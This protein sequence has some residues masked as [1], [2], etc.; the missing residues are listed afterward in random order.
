MMTKLVAGSL[1]TGGRSSPWGRVHI[2]CSHRRLRGGASGDTRIKAPL[3]TSSSSSRF[4]YY[5]SKGNNEE[6]ANAI[7]DDR[8]PLYRSQKYL[9]SLPLPE[10]TDTVAP[11]LSSAI[12]LCPTWDQVAK[13]GKAAEDFPKQAEALQARL[14]AHADARKN[15]SWL[16]EWWNEGYLKDRN[17]NVINVSYFFRLVDND[18]EL[19]EGDRNTSDSTKEPAAIQQQ[20]NDGKGLER[21]AAILQGVATYAERILNGSRP[22]D[23]LASSKDKAPVA[24]CSSQYK[25]LFHACRIPGADQDTYRLYNLEKDKTPLQR[26]CPHT[27]AIVAVG[28]QFYS[29]PLRDVE[30]SLLPHVILKSMLEECVQLSE[31]T[32]ST[33]SVVSVPHLGW[34]TTQNRD[35][36]F[37]DYSALNNASS[38]MSDALHVLQ[39]G[40]VVLCLD[41]DPPAN[42]DQERAMALKLFHGNGESSRW[43]D[44]SIQLVVTRRGGK[45]GL[46][47][48]HSMADGMVAVKLCQYLRNLT[49]DG[50]E[51]ASQRGGSSGKYR[52]T[53]VF[54]KAFVSLDDSYKAQL[55]FRIEHARAKHWE[56]IRKHELSV[57]TYTRYGGA[58]MKH[59][60]NVSPDA[61]IQNA[62]QLASYRYHGEET[63]ATYEST[64]TRRFRH[65]RTEVTR[66]VAPA[67]QTF[68]VSVDY[69]E[70]MDDPE[71]LDLF[72]LAC[73]YHMENTRRALKGFGVD[74]H[75][76]GLEQC[77]RKRDKVPDLF[78]Q[79][80]YT[81]AKEWRL[82]TSTLPDTAPGFGPVVENGLGIGYDIQQNH[83]IF[84]ITC[85]TGGNDAELMKFEITKAL[86][87]I[88]EL[89]PD[90][91]RFRRKQQAGDESNEDEDTD[92]PRSKL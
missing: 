80:V 45:L 51:F 3:S 9:P 55:G 37:K 87:D 36:W 91:K 8:L 20:R 33:S 43:Y 65:G 62:I 5:E 7:E 79:P 15:T 39:S 24:L 84:T 75:L 83:I 58:T 47:G 78:R 32:Q 88:L 92:M 89:L 10:I 25:Y 85:I 35:D 69:E 22:P 14:R 11:F 1:V 74:R 6:D 63:V 31:R 68:A 29:I 19:E 42:E 59:R 72:Q 57:L 64:Q 86:D 61:F 77:L 28:G 70:D 50:S 16:Q 38:E 73:Q 27:H 41:D 21:A 71:R 34:L 18:E 40:L 48:E 76:F 56:Q 53:P 67:T 66:T 44:K 81:Y 90:E 13:V 26:Q 23:T 52:P 30:G 17:S 4:P 2:T 12:P 46:I 54:E 82:S 60:F 49:Y